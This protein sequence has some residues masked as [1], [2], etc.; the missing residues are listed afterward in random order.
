MKTCQLSKPVAFGETFH[1]GSMNNNLPAFG[2]DHAEMLEKYRA[3]IHGIAGKVLVTYGMNADEL[4]RED[5]GLSGENG[6]LRGV[7]GFKFEACNANHGDKQKAAIAFGLM[8]ATREIRKRLRSW[9]KWSRR[10]L[11]RIAN[12]YTAG[13]VNVNQLE[14]I[15][16]KPQDARPRELAGELLDCLPNMER[17]V[18]MAKFGIGENKADSNE[19]AAE[20]GITEAEVRRLHKR[21][22]ARLRSA[23]QSGAFD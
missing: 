11:R 15:S 19:V 22:I 1:P 5:L 17:K 16:D 20:L 2:A 14:S 12:E 13:S 4:R 9:A 6:F 10:G 18:V 3:T 21:A 23:A 7:A 8:C